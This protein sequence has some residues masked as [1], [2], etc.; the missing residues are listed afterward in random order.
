MFAVRERAADVEQWI[1]TM[2]YRI[3]QGTREKSWFVYLQRVSNGESTA[4]IGLANECAEAQL[5]YIREG[6]R[7]P[8]EVPLR[9]VERGRHQPGGFAEVN[10]EFMPGLYQVML[11]DALFSPGAQSAV[12]ML[13]F[14]DVQPQLMWVDLVSFDACDDFAIGLGNFARSVCH[15]HLSAI[16]HQLMPTAVSPM[17]EA[18]IGRS[19][20]PVS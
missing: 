3:K 2:R 14:R 7:V 10:F 18:S 4:A 15:E 11:P 8:V 12:L 17:I 6:E 13:R 19:G 1:E 20:T 16:F 9:A 5:W